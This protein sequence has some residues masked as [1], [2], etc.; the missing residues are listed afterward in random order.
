M[1]GSFEDSQVDPTRN[2]GEAV[3]ESDDTNWVDEPPESTQPEAAQLELTAPPVKT[4]PPPLVMVETAFLAST[5]SLLWL[6]SYYLSIGP[7]MRILFPVP[8]ALVYLRWGLRAAWM[9]AL[10]SGLLL[11]VL[12]GPYLSL[13]FFVP[14]GLLGVQLG[15]L[16]KRQS[17]WFFSI[18]TGTLIS[19]FGFFFRIWLLST[20]LGEDLWAY[21]T[22][23]IADLAE[24]GVG[25]L[26]DWG[27]LGIGVLG[28][29]DL[30]VVQLMTIGVIICS[31]F[32]YLFT[33]H[34]AAWLLLER[35]GNP[36]PEPPQWVQVLLEED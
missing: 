6:V 26:V 25:R 24:W 22:N 16:W 28:Q 17:G 32:I 36:I 31:D 35:L 5:A 23:R 30:T 9:S 1:S 3:S 8:I 4:S 13:L 29:I 7:W 10:V 21:V 11:S 33:V 34:L 19:T 14:Y 2:N 20:F 27:V 18:S 15:G 12:M